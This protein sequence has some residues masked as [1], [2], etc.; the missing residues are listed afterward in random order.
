MISG[1]T[2]EMYEVLEKRVQKREAPTI[3]SR[4][5]KIRESLVSDWH[6]A[7]YSTSDMWD[8]TSRKLPTVPHV[9]IWQKKSISILAR[10][11]SAYDAYLD[12]QGDNLTDKRRQGTAALRILKELGSTAMMLT[13]MIVDDQRIWDTFCPMFQRVVSLAEEIIELDLQLTAQRPTTCMSMAL[14]GPLFEV[15]LSLNICFLFQYLA[16]YIR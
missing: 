4:L 8:H 3:F 15:S 13:P 14:V 6:V 2:W 5:S 10:W 7:S 9:G 16:M 11:S 1:Q 12:I